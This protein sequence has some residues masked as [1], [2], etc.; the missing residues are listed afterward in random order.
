M[1]SIKRYV[2]DFQSLYFFHQKHLGLFE[3]QRFF[4]E[5]YMHS[6]LEYY[7]FIFL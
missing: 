6:V 7:L 4:Y 5:N 1:S 2:K 3:F